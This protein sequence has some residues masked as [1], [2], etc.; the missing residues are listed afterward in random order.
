MWNLKHSLALTSLIAI[1]LW[2]GLQWE[3]KRFRKIVG[4]LEKDL[5]ER[6]DDQF[7]AKATFSSLQ[8]QIVELSGIAE[9]EKLAELEKSLTDWSKS[10]VNKG[11]KKFSQNDEDGVIEAIFDFVE[12]TDKVY[13]EF[14]VESC[15]ECNSKYLRE[16]KGWDTQGSLLL[17]GGYEDKSI[18]LK[19]VIFWPDNILEHF[20]NFG[21]K[22]TFD[23][24]SVDTDSYDFFMLEKIL[25]ADY[26]PRVIAV[27]YNANF[28]IDEAKSIMPPKD[29]K[30]WKRWDSTTYQ[31]MSLL[32]TYYLFNRF[33]YSMVWCNV[34]NC[35]G[36]RDDVLGFPL[37]RPHGEF[38]TRRLDQHRCDDK[39]RWMA[40]INV[41]GTWTGETDSGK[42]SPH[43]RC[44]KEEED[45]DIEEKS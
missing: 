40:V 1:L 38:Y 43:M 8:S 23:F 2:L 10:L 20:N 39:R 42:G 12:T 22:K 36:V 3:E 26:K 25:E 35:I 13:V 31:G 6:F 21:V 41:N 4:E 7:V 24:L 45:E 27:E 9:K 32:A 30:S 16:V 19:K 34:V 29:G 14:G 15:A 33:Q 37:R 18:N 11:F 5:S 44:P 17:D 28:E